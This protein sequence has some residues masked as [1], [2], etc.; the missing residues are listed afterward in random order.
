MDTCGQNGTAKQKIMLF[1]GFLG[2]GKTT[3]MVETANYLKGKG[4]KVALITNDLGENLVDT[5]YA[6][7]SGVP[8]REIQNGCLC[9]D[10]THFLETVKELVQAEAPDII[11]A[12]PVGS[13]VDLV[14]S[15][16]QELDLNFADEYEL[17][18]LI[19]VTDPRRYE[20]IYLHPEN[21]TF[22]DE[23]TYMYKK[24][25][26]DADV[27]LLNK[28]DLISS[29][30]KDEL[31]CS[32]RTTFPHANVIPVITEWQE[33]YEEWTQAFCNGQTASLRKLD[34]DWDYIW[35]GDEH[36]GWYNNTFNYYAK[37]AVNYTPVCEE[38]LKR[39][40]DGFEKEHAEIAHLK[41]LCD[42]HLGYAKAAVTS[43]RQEI[44]FSRT[45]ERKSNNGKMNIN[46]RAIA[47][48]EIIER[49]VNQS[50]LETAEANQLEICCAKY[51]VFDSFEQAEE[52]VSFGSCCCS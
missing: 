31:L 20:S 6:R 36:M 35:R 24:Q 47:L 40:Q 11:F 27:I 43:T 8:V 16:Y 13:C 44:H 50:I 12:E 49:I 19:G 10:V 26:E 33:N 45:L 25:L 9:H 21:N 30:K 22:N 23:T 46:I 1:S 14:R 48:P 37:K 34:I 18:P 39:I 52:P 17:L 38:L 15:V 41:V 4:M 5:N 28:C 2:S 51:Q 7:L 29:E 32:L 3:T 42:I